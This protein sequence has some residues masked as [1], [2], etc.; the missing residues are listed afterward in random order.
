MDIMATDKQFEAN[1]NNAQ[2]S[3][4]PSTERGKSH[5]RF[6]ALKLGVHSKSRILY[7]EDAEDYEA[8]ESETFDLCN[9]VGPIERAVTRRIIDCMW[10]LDRLDQAQHTA[11]SRC[12]I[13][14]QFNSHTSPSHFSRADPHAVDEKLKGLLGLERIAVHDSATVRAELCETARNESESGHVSR[15]LPEAPVGFTFLESFGHAGT[16]R[17]CAEIDRQIVSTTR[18]LLRLQSALDAMQERRKTVV[19]TALEVQ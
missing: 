16:S 14:Q 13:E 17:V 1:R 2:L 5:A 10:R 18:E 7:G 8:L 3:T 15:G 12:Q 11:L 19:G 6:N 4:G 9:P